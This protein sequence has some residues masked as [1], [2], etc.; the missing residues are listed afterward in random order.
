MAE[1]IQWQTKGKWLSEWVTHHITAGILQSRQTERGQP[2]ADNNYAVGTGNLYTLPALPADATFGDPYTNRTER[3]TEVFA[4]DHM[5]WS[6]TFSTWMGL[7]HSRIGRDSVRTDG[8][9]ATS[10]TCLLY[11]SRCV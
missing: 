11:T 4:Y 2:Q 10:Y 3:S 1:A 8:S 7:R 5:A 9:R 6:P